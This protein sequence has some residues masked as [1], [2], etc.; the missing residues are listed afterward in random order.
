MAAA[1]V[2]V[3]NPKTL[4]IKQ[5]IKTD[6][7]PNSLAYNAATQ[8]LFRAQADQVDDGAERDT[9]KIEGS[10]P[11]G[12]LPEFPIGDGK[13]TIFLNI[14][15]KSE[16]VKIDAKT[17]QVVAHWPLTPCE[18]PSGLAYSAAAHRVFRVRQ[19]A[20]GGSD[21]ASARLWR[22]PRRG[23][24]DAAAYDGAQA[25]LYLQR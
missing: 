19:Q 7:N 3:F 2:V 21:A 12:G 23:S 6:A 24:P 13:G 20:A 4:E 9:L 25:D 10:V 8:R 1:Q 5:K 11:V 14:D 22:R 18:S 16:I 17:M 15:D